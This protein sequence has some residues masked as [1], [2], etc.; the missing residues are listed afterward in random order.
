MHEAYKLGASLYVPAVHN[1]LL[2]ALRGDLYP[3]VRSLI[4]C[5]EDSLRD[6]DVPRALA[7]IR[8]L[9]PSLPS[10]ASGPLRFIRARNPEVLGELLSMRGIDRIHGFVIPK[11]DMDSLPAYERLLAG[12]EFWIMPTLE[13]SPVFDLLGQRE[14]RM[15]LQASTIKRQVLA[16]RIGGND[17]LRMLSMKRKRGGTLYETPLGI[18]IQQLV[19]S[20]LPYGFQL[21]AP[22]F[23]FVDDPDTLLNETQIDVMMG[24]IGKTAIHPSQVSV[25]ERA[26]AVSDE[27]LRTAREILGSNTAVFKFNGAMMERTVHEPWAQSVIA[28]G[29]TQPLPVHVEC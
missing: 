22:V 29:A 21:T 13:T 17:L 19:L 14:I 27:D 9:L 8:G 24:L 6:S 2:P 10:R 12:R 16:C 23:D 25:I 26:L 3:A 28:R 5:T 11:A 7:H 15:Y 4:A 1:K 18:L 20:F